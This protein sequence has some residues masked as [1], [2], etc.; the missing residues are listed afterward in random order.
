MPGPNV[1]LDK[2]FVV[3]AAAGIFT[4]QKLA[5]KEHVT[6]AGSAEAVVGILQQIVTAAD[7]ALGQVAD[8]RIHGISRAVASEAISIGTR[9]R[10][11]ANGQVKTMAAA[12]AKQE[13]VGV[14][15]TAA[16]A[17]GDHFDLLLTPSAQFTNA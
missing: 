1:I 15:L 11:A 16:A 12:T 5:A 8:I 14:A 2:G 10:C 13:Q 7:A 17:A 4:C 9:V 6:V 3:D